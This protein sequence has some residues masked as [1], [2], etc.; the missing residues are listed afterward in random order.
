MD[1][2]IDQLLSNYYRNCS[3]IYPSIS[4]WWFGLWIIPNT[5]DFLSEAFIMQ[6]SIFY[7]KY[8]S[9]MLCI[10]HQIHIFVNSRLDSSQPSPHA[11]NCV[12]VPKPLKHT[13]VKPGCH[14]PA[15]FWPLLSSHYPSYR[16][17]K[18]T[19]YHKKKRP[20]ASNQLLNLTTNCGTRRW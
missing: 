8:T 3:T 20:I 5:L 17:K 11:F 12:S 2:W 1:W 18:L 19:S 15:C 10:L 7:T 14:R 9:L 16:I 13:P 6:C 4:I